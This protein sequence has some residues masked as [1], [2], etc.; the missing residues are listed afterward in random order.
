MV[1]GRGALHAPLR[2]LLPEQARVD[3]DELAALQTALYLLEGKFAYAEPLR[4]ALQNL[5][6]A[7][8][9][10]RPCDADCRTASRC[11]TR[12]TRPRC[13]GR[14]GKLEGAISRTM[15]KF[16]YH[17][18]S[19]NKHRASA[20]STRTGCCPTTAVDGDRPGSRT[21]RTRPSASRASAATS[22]SPPAASATSVSPP[23]ST[24]TSTAAGHPG[25]SATSKVKRGSSSQPTPPG[26]SSART[27]MR[28]AR[29]RRLHH[30]LLVVG[31]AHIV[32]P[33]PGRPAIPIEPDELAAGS[34][35][36]AGDASA[37]PAAP[38]PAVREVPAS[39]PP[40]RVRNASRAPASSPTVPRAAKDMK[41]SSLPPRSSSASTLP[42]GAR[43]APP[44]AEPRQLRVRDTVTWRSTVTA[45]TST[46]SCTATRSGSH[47]A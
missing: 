20:R 43:R 32:D 5:A 17:S 39:A 31:T 41:P 4:L 34:S 27:G 24:S 30:R 6:L 15:I 40:V 10:R 25:R 37:E 47:R 3:D 12:T 8:G 13:R 36:T 26:G 21:A 28:R 38:A 45:C 22:G 14:L 46:R 44:T 19:R 35:G 23:T 29:R 9:L 42:R 18:I 2:K 7:L 16:P 11:S 1:Y 33:P